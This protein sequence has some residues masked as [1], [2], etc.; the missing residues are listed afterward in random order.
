MIWDDFVKLFR[1]H[2]IPNSV[3]KLKRHEFLSLQHRNLLVTEYLH[4]FTELSC[5]APYE[6]DNDEKKHDAFLRGLDLEL[7][8]L[9]GAR[10]YPD[11]NTMQKITRM[12]RGT[13]REIL[14]PRGHIPRRRP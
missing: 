3:M 10:V 7:R 1:E 14:K 8:T 5:Y 9:V 4:K 12:R 2:H 11:F 13:K 6:V